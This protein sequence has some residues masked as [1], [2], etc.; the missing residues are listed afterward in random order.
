M[1]SNGS[2]APV[3]ITPADVPHLREPLSHHLGLLRKNNTKEETDELKEELGQR[4]KEFR[5]SKR[6]I[7]F[8]DKEYRYYPDREFCCTPLGLVRQTQAR[9]VGASGAE[10]L[11]E[12]HLKGDIIRVVHQRDRRNNALSDP[13]SDLRIPDSYHGKNVILTLDRQIQHITDRAV[14]KHLRQ[15]RLLRHMRWSWKSAQA[16]SSPCQAIPPKT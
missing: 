2:V 4:I 12:D 15:Q 11:Y 6:S 8:T 9:L 13:E 10:R 7:F 5:S 1:L 14:Q 16:K 3:R